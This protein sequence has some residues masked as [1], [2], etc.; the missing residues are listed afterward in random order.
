MRVLFLSGLL[1]GAV[2]VFYLSWL[3]NPDLSIYGILPGWLA[4]WTDAQENQNIRT[5][6]PFLLLGLLSGVWLL[7]SKQRW[8]SWLSIWLL[9][10]AMVSVAE[11]GQLL[12]PLRHFDWGDIMWGGTGAGT[13]MSLPGIIR[14]ALFLRRH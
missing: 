1:I 4:R 3:P 9:L 11:V 12:I 2:I 7:I 14:L 8:K 13:G 5:A 6:V 10:V